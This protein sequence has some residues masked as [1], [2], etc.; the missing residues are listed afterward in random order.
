MKRVFVVVALVILIV[1][2]VAIARAVT[3]P[4]KQLEPLAAAPP[5]AI[6]R[7]AALARFTRAVQ[8]RTVS[9][10]NE[11][12]AGPVEHDAFIAWL[13]QAYPRVH[14]SLARE[15]VNGS[16]LFI[17]NGTDSSLAP[18]LLMGHFDV[19]P[20]EPGT[21]AK[22]EHPPFSGTVAGGYV[23]G[24]GTIDDKLTVIALLEAAE[25]LLAEGYRPKR[26]IYFA[27]GHD[28]EAGGRGAEAMAK[29]LVGRG[30]KFDAVIDEGG[31]ISIDSIRGAPRPVAL[32][33]IAE[34][35]WASVE[36]T[37]RGSGGHSSMPPPRTEVGAIAAAVDAVQRKPFPADVR[38]ASTHT[39]RWLAP[40][41][42]FGPKLV[43]ANLWL[44]EPLLKLQAKESQ[45]FN[46]TLRTTTA[47]TI[48]AGG[49]KDNVIP[50]HA[51]AV[52]NFRILP[53]DSARGVLAHVK[54]ALGESHVEARLAGN[55]SDPSPVSDPD[56][57][58]FRALQRTIGQVFPDVIVAP[59]LVIG[60]TDAR[61]YRALSPNIY[62]FLPA[63]IREA[64]LARIHGTN[65]R[66]AAGDYFEAIR[67]YRTLIGNMTG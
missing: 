12:P 11:K 58:Q 25:S 38:G 32:I 24:R 20:I 51:R 55:Y 21:E 34:K 10:G 23:W 67:F 46:A 5:L 62:R 37:A 63:R 52:I 8:F 7:N 22:W 17:W 19:V 43:M 56:A 18:L 42:P 3:L 39:F 40:E 28:E 29:R 15:V 33:G 2:G 61:H 30:V 27:F 48:I 9:Y 60:A 36:L 44:F 57:P 1:L 13:A 54:D 64:D 50:S 35:G 65:E 66:A 26:S 14:A 6:D 31:I 59:Y 49:V 47:P 4:S 45:S 53:G 16:L 41:M